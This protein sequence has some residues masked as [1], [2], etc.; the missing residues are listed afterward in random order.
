[1]SLTRT[2]RP[3]TAETTL[4]TAEDLLAAG[5]IAPENFSAIQ[6]MSERYAI[7]ITPEMRELVQG[8]DDPIARQFVPD[9]RETTVLPQE[10]LDPIGDYPH[11]PLKALVHRYKNR[12]LL[13]PT[14]VCAVYCRFCFRREMV[15]P[16][17]DSVTQDDVDQALAYI[18]AHPEISEVIL[19]GGDPLMLSPKRLQALMQALQAMPHIRW[20][21]FHT[22]VP[23]VA[24]GKI[25][26]DLIAVLKGIKTVVMAVHANHAREFTP[27][28]G[29]ALARLAQSGVVLVGQSVL[30]KGINDSVDA[31]AELMETM[32]ANRIKPYYLHHPDLTTGTSHFRL[33]FEQG[34]S[35]MNQLRERVSGLCVPQYTLDIPGGYT[36][37]CIT[38]ET[39]IPVTGSPGDY[40]LKDASGRE[41]K[42]SDQ[43]A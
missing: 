41:Y 20:I 32:M 26:N 19:S 43:L 42:Y 36:K 40:I 23:V 13:K 25:T 8:H 17:G 21:R 14:N 11:S 38:R 2:T 12:V 27:A 5:V 7:A 9:I 15:G 37:I 24:P 35:L 4:R 30:L 1:M 22:R 3:E 6:K 33:S 34:M 31:L 39:V 18:A 28:A 29:A 16:E 10:L